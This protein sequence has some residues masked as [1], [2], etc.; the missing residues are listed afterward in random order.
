[1]TIEANIGTVPR[2]LGWDKQRIRTRAADLLE[3]VGLD[4][5]YGKRYPTQLSGGQRQR[6]EARRP[7]RRRWG[8]RGPGGGAGRP[9][10]PPPPRVM[11][12]EEP[13]GALDPITR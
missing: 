6:R 5:E 10:F 12:M 9:R 4:P 11:L 1:M 13:F 7:P 2:L 3:L 8:G